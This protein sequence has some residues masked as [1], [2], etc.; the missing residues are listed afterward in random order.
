MKATVCQTHELSNGDLRRVTVGNTPV[1]LARS[2]DNFYAL[3]AVCSHA[4]APLDQGLMH[5]GRIVCPWHMAS[6]AVQTGAHCEPPGLDGLTRYPLIVDGRDIIVEVPDDVGPHQT[7]AMATHHPE[8][9]GRVFAI[10]G[11]GIAGQMAAETLRQEGYE[12]RIVMITAE[13]EIPYKRTALSKGYLQSEP[14]DNLPTLR[15][16]SFFADHGIEV[17]R[18][19]PVTAV[20]PYEHSIT[21]ANGDVLNYHQLLLATGG[22]A[23]QLGVS[24]ADLANVFTL[25]KAED[26]AQIVESAQ[27]AQR[28]VV[29]GSSFIGMEAAA[30]LTQAGL[31]VTVVSPEAVPFE[32]IFGPVVGR[33]LQTLHEDNGV[34]FCLDQKATEFVGEAAVEA[35]VLE[36]GDRVPADLVVVGIGIQPATDFIEAMKLHP[37]DGSILVNAYLHA[38]ESVFA[39]GDVARYP[40][41]RSGSDIRIEHWRL[42]AQHGRIAA[43]NMLGQSIPFKGVPFF[44]TKQFAMNLHYVGHA[45]RWNDVIIHG[46]LESGEFMAFYVELGQILAVLANGYTQELIAIAE[47]MRLGELPTADILINEPVDWVAQLKRPVAA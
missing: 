6:F 29:I 8:S 17:W 46:N 43:R 7:P 32:K 9:D 40:D 22:K 42:A 12:G 41:P 14:A 21:F 13:A 31:S 10:L 38:A 20:K 44:W 19:R 3:G 39:A 2:D 47:L 15:P 36:N 4:G 16:E 34:E 18:D 26:A 27:D 33:R 23:R 37:G 5:D 30:S 45:E 25:H 28:A 35:V 1:L 11:A 24:G